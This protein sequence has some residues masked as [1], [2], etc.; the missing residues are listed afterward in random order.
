MAY[1]LKA[2]SYNPLTHMHIS[3][4]KCFTSAI[5]IRK[6]EKNECLTNFNLLSSLDYFCDPLFLMNN[7]YD[8]LCFFIDFS[9]PPWEFGPSILVIINA[10]LWLQKLEYI[11]LVK[12]CMNELECLLIGCKTKLWV[13]K[14]AHLVRLFLRL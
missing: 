7:F 6:N 10:G 1:G 4:R 12:D 5:A 3:D 2:S 13:A 11:Y 9:L 14:L 8:I